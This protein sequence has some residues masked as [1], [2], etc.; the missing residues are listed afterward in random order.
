VG[1]TPEEFEQAR[2]KRNVGREKRRIAASRAHNEGMN[3]PPPLDQ[4]EYQRWRDEADRVLAGARLQAEAGLHNWACFAAEQA[5]Q[6]AIKGLLHGLGRGP[7]GHDLVALGEM[8]REAG[9]GVGS[10]VADA[11]KRLGRHYIAA[12]YPD[13]HAS[14]PPGRH[15][16]QADVSEALEDSETLLRFVDQTWRELRG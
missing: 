11:L 1:F 5:A 8:A 14:G 7:W 15:Y 3:D 12:R 10:E 4:E 6:L 2:T 13:A 16:G 9:V